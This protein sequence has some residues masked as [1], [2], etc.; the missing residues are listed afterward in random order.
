MLM[1][2]NE[3]TKLF[4]HYKPIWYRC[5]IA[6]DTL[7]LGSKIGFGWIL[8]SLHGAIWRCSRILL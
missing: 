4:S 5:S 7:L 6:F 3:C 1:K 8:D 2:L